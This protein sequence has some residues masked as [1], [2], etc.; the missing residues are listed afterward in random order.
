MADGIS[1]DSGR[2]AT[3][4]EIPDAVC[5]DAGSICQIGGIGLLESVRFRLVLETEWLSFHSNFLPLQSVA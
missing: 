4:A 5:T 1:V 2:V 3:G